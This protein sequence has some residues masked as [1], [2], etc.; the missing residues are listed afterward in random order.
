MNYTSI[1]GIL[2]IFFLIILLAVTSCAI[3]R[4]IYTENMETDGIL[5]RIVVLDSPDF[6]ELIISMQEP[7]YAIKE[8]VF[9]INWMPDSVEIDDYNDDS[10]LD[11]KII[12]T[13]D[14]VHYFYSTEL[15][16]VDI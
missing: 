10:R 5:I 13:G 15:G 8:R 4:V 12:S 3:N 14:E 11:I 16:I 9:R 2:T 6:N 7:G 1:L